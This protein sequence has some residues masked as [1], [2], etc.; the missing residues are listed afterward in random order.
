MWH[1]GHAQGQVFLPLLLPPDPRPAPLL[2]DSESSGL[3]L[4]DPLGPSSPFV[5]SSFSRVSVRPSSIS[6]T[7]HLKIYM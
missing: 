6:G 3:G 7:L 2:C 4:R 5:G 1:A